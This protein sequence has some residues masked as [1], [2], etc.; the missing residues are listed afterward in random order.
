MNYKKIAVSLLLTFLVFFGVRAIFLLNQNPS[1]PNTPL[2][3]RL[4]VS[5]TAPYDIQESADEINMLNDYSYR[6]D[7]NKLNLY[8]FS[9]WYCLGYLTRSKD[10]FPFKLFFKFYELQKFTRL[11]SVCPSEFTSKDLLAFLNSQI[12]FMNRGPKNYALIML[13][14]YDPIRAFT[15]QA[16]PIYS[17]EAPSSFAPVHLSELG[18]VWAYYK[19]KIFMKSNEWSEAPQGSL[20][21]MKDFTTLTEK[22]IASYSKET[23]K[24]QMN[25]SEVIS[26]VTSFK[27]MQ[28]PFIN[29]WKKLPEEEAQNPYVILEQLMSAVFLYN[30]Q[31]PLEN[32]AENLILKVS[33]DYPQFFEQSKGLGE[34]FLYCLLNMSS[35]KDEEFIQKVSPYLKKAKSTHIQAALYS[36]NQ[37][38]SQFK[39]LIRREKMVSLSIAIKMLRTQN[40]IP[41]IVTYPFEYPVFANNDLREIATA[42]QANLLD[43]PSA[44]K[45]RGIDESSLQTMGGHLNPHGSEIIA[46]IIYQRVLEL[47]A[48]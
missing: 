8:V 1:N 27:N 9:D 18:D 38:Y 13:G 48:Q 40:I 41:I 4:V 24:F 37:N 43:L 22:Y 23:N 36:S 42:N 25:S 5:D 45:E 11:I 2:L 7:G 34:I 16:Q 31:F 29:F 21:L 47:N 19:K 32:D 39:E 6:K 14:H 26:S 17:F 20:Q 33:Q 15:P 3:S 44:L 30:I 46:Q 35:P 28:T 12:Q 10:T